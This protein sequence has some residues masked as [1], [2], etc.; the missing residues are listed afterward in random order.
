MN[1]YLIIFI[2]GFPYELIEKTNFLNRFSYKCPL[3]PGIGYS[4]NIHA[5]IFAGLSADRIGFFNT[6]K[7]EPASSPFRKLKSIKGLLG[8]FGDNRYLNWFFRNAIKFICGFDSL[9]IPYKFID[10][11]APCGCPVYSKNFL[12]FKLWPSEIT[13]QDIIFDTDEKR[14]E[15]A[16]EKVMKDKG[17]FLF[18]VKLDRV[19]HKF[20]LDS[21]EYENSFNCLS[22]WINNLYDKFRSFCPNGHIVV[23]SDH[24]MSKIKR[25]VQFDLEKNF[26]YAGLRSYVYFLDTTMLRVWYL[27]LKAKSAIESF[28]NNKDYGRLLTEQERIDFGIANKKWADS[29]FLLNEG[30]VFD[31]SFLEKGHP[32]AMHG[33]HPHLPWQKGI[34]LYSGPKTFTPHDTITTLECHNILK[35]ILR[36]GK[37]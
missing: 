8:N 1:N 26:P 35:E 24:G 12:G 20:G 14:Y 37:S 11:F 30:Y 5:E 21:N 2:D 34:F 31:P 18:F 22:D 17:L 10:M 27:D 25:V 9:N 6:W 28:L 15:L 4:V 3:T 32:L 19:A 7:F 29:I 33:Y 16:K 23:L 36:S 13:E